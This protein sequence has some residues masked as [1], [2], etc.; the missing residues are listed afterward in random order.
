[1][2]ALTA[3]HL[4]EEVPKFS[5]FIH[6][7]ATLREEAVTLLP[8]WLPQMEKSI[9][10]RPGSG[11]VFSGDLDV[12]H[13]EYSQDPLSE[14]SPRLELFE[15]RDDIEIQIES[16]HRSRRE[17][18]RSPH[19]GRRDEERV[20]LLGD[21]GDASMESS[22][23]FFSDD[24]RKVPVLERM[25]RYF[26]GLVKKGGP[27]TPRRRTGNEQFSQHFMSLT[28]GKRIA[29]PVRVEPKV[30]FANE[31]TFLSWLHCKCFVFANHTVCI[32]LGGLAL[33]LMNFGDRVGVISGVIFTI[34]SL[35]FMLYALGL[36]HWRAGLCTVLR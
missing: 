25:S 4:V 33:G 15:Q 28:P 19:R 5:K 35:L 32:V 21:D 30:F 27:S 11:Y 16:P 8:F 7:I 14:I 1:M 24:A 9:L 3:S 36:Y 12:A 31:R 20:P 22:R 26:S 13:S 6:G 18:E 23:E 2:T 34:V 29:L 17:E 10:K